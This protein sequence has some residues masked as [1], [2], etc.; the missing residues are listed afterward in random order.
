MTKNA[1]REAPVLTRSPTRNDYPHG[2]CRLC[3]SYAIHPEH[4]GRCPGVDM[5]LC[6]VCYWRV[7]AK[8]ANRL[9]HQL[10]GLAAPTDRET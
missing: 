3:G 7:R 6:D 10:C 2:R 8:T 5:D 4:Y 9:V 1:P